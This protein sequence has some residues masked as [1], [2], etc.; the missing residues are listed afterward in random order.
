MGLGDLPG[1]PFMSD[2]SDVSGDGTTVVGRS[3]SSSQAGSYEAFR[4]T[5]PGPMMGLGDFGAPTP[6]SRAQAVSHDGSVVV[7]FG[8]AGHAFDRKPFAWTATGGMVQLED[9]AGVMTHGQAF[10]VSADGAVV[11]GVGSGKTEPNQPFRWTAATGMVS[12]GDVPGGISYAI[13]WAISADGS[14]IVGSARTAFDS[15]DEMFL[16]RD[17]TGFVLPDTLHGE[18]FGSTAFDVSADGTIA[19]GY[20]VSGAMIWDAEHGMRAL[21]DVLVGD[22]GLDL[23]GWSLGAA[24]G[25]S[26]DGTTITGTGQNPAGNSEAWIALVPR[27][28]TAV[29]E[30]APSSA[31]GRA[32]RL[33]GPNPFASRVELEITASPGAASVFSIDGRLVRRLSGGGAPGGTVIVWDGRDKTGRD[34]PPGVYLIAGSGDRRAACKVTRLR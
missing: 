27:T 33:L 32:I 1:G 31:I 18:Q 28:A 16:W 8:H 15:R 6:R 21:R 26:D 17:D 5:A 4:W 34:A 13:A 23:T 12:L 3:A 9:P 11:V 22:H 25:I 30:P 7:G 10:D 19:V 14:T 24:W 2:A 29:A 20:G